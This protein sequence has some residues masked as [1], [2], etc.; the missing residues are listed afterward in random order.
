MASLFWVAWS[1]ISLNEG[2]RDV[3]I[4]FCERCGLP[5]AV[6]RSTSDYKWRFDGWLCQRNA[7]VL[8][9]RDILSAKRDVHYPV[10]TD[11]EKATLADLAENYFEA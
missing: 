8:S 2:R 4:A 3:A 11:D 7:G 9:E 1:S 6:E 5:Y 10:L